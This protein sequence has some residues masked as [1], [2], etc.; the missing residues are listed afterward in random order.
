MSSN[1]AINVDYFNTIQLQWTNRKLI[2]QWSR[3]VELFTNFQTVSGFLLTFV[4]AA[5]VSSVNNGI[6]KRLL[7][8]QIGYSD[9]VNVH[10]SH[11]TLNES[12]IFHAFSFYRFQHIR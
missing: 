11:G 10:A 6:E 12:A 2:A 5:N 4:W 1:W 3:D 8:N 9:I 7:F